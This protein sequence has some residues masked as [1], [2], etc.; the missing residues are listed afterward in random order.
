MKTIKYLLVIPFVTT[1]IACGKDDPIVPETPQRPEIPIFQFNK[2]KEYLFEMKLYRDVF[3]FFKY[4]AKCSQV[5]SNIIV[6]DEILKHKEDSINQI[7]IYPATWFPQMAVINNIGFDINEHVFNDFSLAFS[8]NIAKSGE[9]LT[10]DKYVTRKYADHGRDSLL[11]LFNQQ[12]IY[13]QFTTFEDRPTTFRPYLRVDF[14]Q[15]MIGLEEGDDA[16]FHICGKDINYTSDIQVPANASFQLPS[17]IQK[18]DI[19]PNEH[20]LIYDRFDGRTYTSEDN[21]TYKTMVVVKK[22]T[23]MKD[24]DS[25]APTP[26]RPNLSKKYPV[27]QFFKNDKLWLEAWCSKYTEYFEYNRS[28]NK[29]TTTLSFECYTLKN[30]YQYWIDYS[31][32]CL[33]IYISDF[34][35]PNGNDEFTRVDIQHINFISDEKK[36]SKETISIE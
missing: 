1:I 27:I 3:K 7:V 19:Y 33:T 25:S 12:N 9:L 24:F 22:L 14:R 31:D 21:T 18:P 13:G 8:A 28:E 20:A 11:N 5:N 2:E 35:K 10:D 36:E 15:D 23:E 16:E 6:S 29:T 30:G 4:N 34:S 17:V 26:D 32:R